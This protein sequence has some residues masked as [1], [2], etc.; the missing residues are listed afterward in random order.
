VFVHCHRG[1]DRTGM[2][3]AVYR[4]VVCGWSKEEAL[5][6][7]TNGPFGYDG[8]FSNVVDFLW[9]LDVEELKRQVPAGK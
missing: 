6:E 3:C 8:M 7:M 2:M 9:R 5:D 4:M 1:I